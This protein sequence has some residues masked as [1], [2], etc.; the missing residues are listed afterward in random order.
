MEE[1][2]IECF[3]ARNGRY[4]GKTLEEGALSC[5]DVE[6]GYLGLAFWLDEP[7][8]QD[9]EAKDSALQII[10]FRFGKEETAGGPGMK[11]CAFFQFGSTFTV[12]NAALFEKAMIKEQTPAHGQA[13][14]EQE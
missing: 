12:M 10:R 9:D 13:G 5:E 2:L 4:I 11:P 14:Q 1:R 3:E 7:L 8:P 6:E